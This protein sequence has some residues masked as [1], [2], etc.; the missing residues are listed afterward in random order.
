M[1]CPSCKIPLKPHYHRDAN[2]PSYYFCQDRTAAYANTPHYKYFYE[3]GYGYEVFM[4]WEE[5]GKRGSMYSLKRTLEEHTV[6]KVELTYHVKDGFLSKPITRSFTPDEFEFDSS[7]WDTMVD[8]V[9]RM[10]E[11]SEIFQ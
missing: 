3:D 10:V 2:K 8:K 7:D 1:I 5:G 9:R 6:T 11:I 4:I